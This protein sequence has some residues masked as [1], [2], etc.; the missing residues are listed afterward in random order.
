MKLKTTS[1]IFALAMGTFGVIS[2]N[3]PTQAQT[4]KVDAPIESPVDAR[5]SFRCGA[6]VGRTSAYAIATRNTC[7]RVQVAA[8]CNRWY[9]G[10]SA[11]ST[12]IATCS[13]VTRG[14]VRFR[15]FSTSNWTRWLYF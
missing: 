13:S 6:Y 1:V 12:S 4:T 8:L 11:S 15:I 5:S 9:Y 2:S 14:A 7:Y 3:F 10:P